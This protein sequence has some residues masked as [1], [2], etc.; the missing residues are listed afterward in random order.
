MTRA[1]LTAPNCSPLRYEDA[2]RRDAYDAI[3]VGSGPNGLAAAITLAQAGRQVLVVEGASDV[4][5]GTRTRQLCETGFRHDVCSAVHPLGVAS[6]FFRNVPLAEHGLEWVF[7]EASLVH[8]LAPKQPVVMY[9]SVE[10]T[11]EGLGA[12]GEAYRRLLEPFVHRGEELLDLLLA[13][14]TFFP[15]SPLLMARFGLR[16]IRSTTGLARSWFKDE[17]ARGLFAGM[18]A[19]SV[20]PLERALTAAVGMLFGVM[21]HIRSWPVAKGGS[22]AIADSMVRYLRSLGGEVVADF[23]VKDMNEL[24]RAKA[25]LFDTTPAA[26][27]DIAGDSLPKKYR[28]RLR[29]FRHGPGVFKLDWTLD[30]PIPWCNEDFAKAATVHIGGD[31]AEVAAAERAPWEGRCSDKPFILLSQQS[32]FDSTRA[33]EGKHVGWAYCHVPHGAGESLGADQRLAE[34]MEARIEEFAP[35]F[36]DL[37]RHRHV[38]APSDMQQHNANYP[39]GDITGGVMDWRQLFTRPIHLLNPYATAASNIFLCSAS[40]PPGAGVHGMC[41]YFAARA[42][43]AGA[44]AGA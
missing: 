30:G 40:T 1:E 20:L 39:G 9:P 41:G 37:I 21:G 33:P 17:A 23:W 2:P 15:K 28:E 11:A 38:M 25:Y 24:P 18:A 22:Q 27:A 26:M 36:R 42:A 3:I 7:P 8:A 12:D 44:L 6:P 10:R 29:A 35:G 31:L 13:P 5:G 14:F 16:G 19:H 32:L 4:G 34:C 43:L